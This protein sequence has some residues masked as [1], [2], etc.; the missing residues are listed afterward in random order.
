M[1]RLRWVAVALAAALLPIPDWTAAQGTPIASPLQFFESVAQ[2]LRVSPD[3]TKI[4]VLD[5]H[6][7]LCEFALPA[8]QEIAA[9][10]YEN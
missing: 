1:N 4:A 9:Q 7:S 8:Q 10:T 6:T 2:P 5:P 3:G